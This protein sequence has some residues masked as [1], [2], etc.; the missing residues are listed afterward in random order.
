[1]RATLQ[2]TLPA[3]ADSPGGLVVTVRELTVA[4]VRALLIT[5]E[6]ASDPLQA[7]MFDG[8][9]LGDLLLMSDASAADLEQFAPSELQPLVDACQKLNPHFFRVRAALVRVARQ[10][11]SEFEQTISTAHAAS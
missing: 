4:E 2:I 5:E 7:M 8:F 9:G 10:L 6:Q 3:D 11:V 1:M